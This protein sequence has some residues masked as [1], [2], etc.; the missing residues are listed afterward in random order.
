MSLTLSLMPVS[1]HAPGKKAMFTKR[2]LSTIGVVDVA[3][4]LGRIIGKL[5]KQYKKTTHIC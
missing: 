3:Q 5:H 4:S 2:K 1:Y